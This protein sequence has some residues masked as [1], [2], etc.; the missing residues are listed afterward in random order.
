MCATS[1]QEV[2]AE[3]PDRT[4][5]EEPNDHTSRLASIYLRWTYSYMNRIL[6]KGSRQML[7]DGTHISEDDLYVVPGSMQASFLVSKFR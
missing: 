3:K 1:G 7:P 6:S 2:Q 5:P 4:W